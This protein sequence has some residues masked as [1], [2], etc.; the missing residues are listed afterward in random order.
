MNNIIGGLLGAIGQGSYPAAAMDGNVFVMAAQNAGIGTD[1][2]TLN[3]I[4]DL[5]N[6]GIAPEMAANMIAQQNSVQKEMPKE[7]PQI[8]IQQILQMLKGK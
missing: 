1:I 3:M 5:V 8:P 6:Q 7:S 4:V 2:E